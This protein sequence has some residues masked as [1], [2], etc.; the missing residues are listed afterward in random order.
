MS[1]FV[2]IKCT[3]CLSVCPSIPCYLNF[4]VSRAIADIPGAV[5]VL[6]AAGFSESITGAAAGE[7]LV[8]TRQDPGLLYVFS[9]VLQSCALQVDSHC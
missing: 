8:L 2:E 6:Y 5:D 1:V 7:Q 9:S 3:V 4:F